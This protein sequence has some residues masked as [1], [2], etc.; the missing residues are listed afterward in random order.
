M[1][2]SSVGS[3]M[4][5]S[6]E[7]QGGRLAGKQMERRSEYLMEQICWKQAGKGRGGFSIQ[8]L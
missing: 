5:N 7:Q 8:T 4:T 6:E 1:H 2:K 3:V